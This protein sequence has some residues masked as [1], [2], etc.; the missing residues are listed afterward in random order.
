MR[1]YISLILFC[2]SSFFII[3]FFNICCFAIEPIET[4]EAKVNK[5]IDGNNIIV[6][7]LKN[8]KTFKVSLYGISVPKYDQYY[9]R[10]TIAYLSELI[11]HKKVF[12]SVYDIDKYSGK[13]GIIFVN[14]KNINKNLVA[15][16]YALVYKEY[17]KLEDVDDWINKENNAKK[18]KIGLWNPDTQNINKLAY[19]IPFIPFFL[20]FFYIYFS[21]YKVAL[22]L[23]SSISFIL[24]S[25]NFIFISN[26]AYQKGMEQAIKGTNTIVV[27]VIKDILEYDKQFTEK[28]IK[29]K[30][31]QKNNIFSEIFYNKEKN[32]NNNIF[33]LQGFINLHINEYAKERLNSIF[34]NLPYN[35]RLKV[36]SEQDV[37]LLDIKKRPSWDDFYYEDYIDKE[38]ITIGT[39]TY[40]YTF[41]YKYKAIWHIALIRS[42]T[43]SMYPDI[44][45]NRN[46][47]TNLWLMSLILYNW[48]RS[49]N[50]WLAF[51]IIFFV[52]YPFLIRLEEYRLYK[53]VLKKELN[54]I[55]LTAKKYNEKLENINKSYLAKTNK[56]KE[57]Y[58]KEILKLKEGNGD[59]KTAIETTMQYYDDK[60]KAVTQKYNNELKSLEKEKEKI[61][62]NYEQSNKRI[63]DLETEL[64][65]QTNKSF[66]NRKKLEY[67]KSELKEEKRK[68][69]IEE[70][71]YIETNSNRQFNFRDSAKVLILGGDG[72]LK[73]KDV[74]GI[75]NS[76]SLGKDCFEWIHYEDLKNYDITILENTTEYSDI[77]IGN[78]PHKTKN[79]TGD[80]SLVAHLENNKDKYP[81][82]QIVRLSDGSLGKITKTIL[83]EKIKNSD[84]YLRKHQKTENI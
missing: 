18:Q 6:S 2:I 11:S 34:D 63:S 36:S 52:L 80:I 74:A 46:F 25:L 35:Y 69:I 19:Y 49:V 48:Q 39:E 68:N 56:I 30:K 7:D 12:I 76:F 50:W 17:N 38:K 59:N 53:K 27:E 33:N 60:I 71:V 75:F 42:I 77:I 20:L 58:E 21:R 78:S 62:D 44:I 82:L 67:L 72:G 1:K 26:D 37:V 65:K 79:M 13:V 41:G 28:R 3:I 66:Y 54:K 14:N 4:I 40:T 29:N 24:A 51:I 73:E 70:K 81:K 83:K 22:I 15:N 43:F 9:G 57:N 10:Q 84:K 31:E 47:D 64:E 61:R 16:G 23:T 5:I 8:D 32:N 55:N 45:V